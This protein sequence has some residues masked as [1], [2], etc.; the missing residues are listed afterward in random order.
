MQMVHGS[1]DGRED[2]LRRSDP[3]QRLERGALRACRAADVLPFVGDSGMARR[4]E[5]HQ[6]GPGMCATVDQRQDV[7]HLRRWRPTVGAAADLTSRIS[8]QL[9]RAALAPASVIAALRRGRTDAARVGAAPL[10][11]HTVRLD[12]KRSPLCEC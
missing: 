7:M 11:W 1:A 10:S 4:A 9:P 3:S 2:V 8:R 12:L 6:V 5:A